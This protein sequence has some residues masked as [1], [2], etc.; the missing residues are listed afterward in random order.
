MSASL[1]TYLPFTYH[2]PP[3]LAY[4]HLHC[5]PSLEHRLLYTTPPS[6]TNIMHK[7]SLSNLPSCPLPS[8]ITPPLLTPNQASPL[9]RT[10]STQLQSSLKGLPLYHHT[11]THH[12][13]PR[14]SKNSILY[15][16]IQI[17]LRSLISLVPT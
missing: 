15:T 1:Y 5:H 7:Y 14:N 11:Y 6:S 2:A 9:H 8:H 3:S 16:E 10:P 13:S 17:Y 12:I 4:I